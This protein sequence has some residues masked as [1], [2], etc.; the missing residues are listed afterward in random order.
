[1]RAMP[2]VPRGWPSRSLSRVGADLS[3]V[4]LFAVVA[5][6]VAAEDL[7]YVANLRASTVSVIDVASRRVT[8]RIPVGAEP[9]G[10]AVSPDRNWVFVANFAA[11]TVSMID[12]ATRTVIATIPVGAG[13]VGLAVTP[14]GAEVYAADKTA[15]T[16]TVID[17]STRAVSHTIPLQSGSG[18][19]GVAITPDGAFVYVTTSRAAATSIIATATHQVTKTLDLAA[20]RIVMDPTRPK[21]YAASFNLDRVTIL[22]TQTQAIEE[23]IQVGM[24]PTG[25]AVTPDGALLYIAGESGLRP[26]DLATGALLP[27]V[28][29]IEPQG[30]R[31][32]AVTTDGISA[33]VTGLDDASVSVVD[34][35]TGQFVEAICVDNGPFALAIVPAPTGATVWI[36]APLAG[37]KLYTGVSLPVSIVA[38]GGG[39]ALTSW[40][41]GILAGG[42]GTT[43]LASGASEVNGTVVAEMDG[44]AASGKSSLVLEVEN[45]AGDR[46][47]SRI[48]LI[49][50]DPPYAVM[51]IDPQNRIGLSGPVVDGSGRLVVYERADCSP[52]EVVVLDIDHGIVDGVFLEDAGDPWR[53][54]RDASTLVYTR[55]RDA[56]VFLD[57]ASNAKLLYPYLP[58]GEI[59]RAG[60]RMT[61]LD[62]VP[63]DNPDVQLR[64]V[65][66][67]DRELLELRQVTTFTTDPDMR[68]RSAEVISGGGNTIAFG[69]NRP[70]H[71]YAYDVASRELR[72]LATLRPNAPFD[73]PSISDD[74]RWLAFV[75]LTA[76]HPDLFTGVV[77]D[78]ASGVFDPP[79]AALDGFRTVD[80]LITP[81]GRYEVISAAADLDPSVGN[82]DG[83]A[84]LFRFDRESGAFTQITDT[85]GQTPFAYSPSINDDGTAAAFS[86]QQQSRGTCPA[87][88][89]QRDAAT[90]FNFGRTYTVRRRPGNRPPVLATVHDVRLLVDDLL[91]LGFV[92]T[93]PDEERIA[94]FLQL[95]N[96]I[97]MPL[98]ASVADNRDGTAQFFWR[99]GQ[100]EIGDYAF[101]LGAFDSGGSFA[102]EE[103]SVRVCGEFLPDGSCAA[104]PT[105]TATWTETPTATITATRSAS[106]TTSATPT[107]TAPPTSAIPSSATLTTTR[108]PTVTATSAV[109]SPTVTSIPTAAPLSGGGGCQAGAG[110]SGSWILLLAVLVCVGRGVPPR[111]MVRGSAGVTARAGRLAL[112]KDARGVIQPR[113]SRAE[114][115]TAR[116]PL[117]C[118]ITRS[119][120]MCSPS[121][122]WWCSLT[123]PL[124]VIGSPVF[125]GMRKVV[126]S[127][128]RIQPGSCWRRKSSR[129]AVSIGPGTMMPR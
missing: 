68:G 88:G 124:R 35:A 117:G 123:T 9:N 55:G 87:V 47:T 96:R 28:E 91:D 100:D 43:P 77:L 110:E 56:L 127:R 73:R 24:R 119:T 10:V 81:D 33:Y 12:T 125:V 115:V 121:A 114:A 17:V 53:F 16:V 111:R 103:F 89:P 116:S 42:G 60:K 41:L 90:G 93:D 66:L 14:N 51:P 64:Q 102:I 106:P 62:D 84:E 46:A 25:L 128:S 7:A 63:A 61:F 107:A 45:A 69:A 8:G 80:T 78:L 126:P 98:T 108:T 21:A 50:S 71:V 105:P 1:M 72:D 99:P 40:S 112:R 44:G 97:D 85:V 82:A 120:T 29:G 3:A 37:T 15:S 49:F 39:A 92:A 13:P 83:N 59:D 129:K 54:S 18:P 20:I 104:T 57:L 95:A 5:D 101:R 74:G 30:S 11:S 109:S 70:L 118:S 32:V 19:N 2:L 4:L 36:T 48:D 113:R 58:L 94:F 67:Y 75:T 65:F 27:R 79:I 6:P 22:D 31:A 38:R 86:M 23:Q 122:R 26:L 34:V 76:A 52:G